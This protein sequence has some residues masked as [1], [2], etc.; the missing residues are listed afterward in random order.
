[1]KERLRIGRRSFD[2]EKQMKAFLSGESI[3]E[4]ITFFYPTERDNYPG[5]YIEKHDKFI[6]YEEAR[7]EKYYALDPAT[8]EKKKQTQKKVLSQSARII[9]SKD[10]NTGNIYVIDAFMDRK[11]PSTIVYEMY[12][13]HHHHNFYKMGFEE[14]LFR[15]LYKDHIR[16]VG[17]EWNDEYQTHP[18]PVSYTH[19]T[20]P[21]KA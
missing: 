3:F 9:A 7:F 20:L 21:T 5:F 16:L 8:G 11:P 1:M 14:N 17:N 18:T 2:A 6:E 12:D 19:L 13:L 10:L 4:N 15:D